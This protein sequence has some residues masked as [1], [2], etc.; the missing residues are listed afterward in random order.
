MSLRETLYAALLEHIQH[1]VDQL[2]EG[3][4]TINEWT[5]WSYDEIAGGESWVKTVV[6]YKVPTEIKRNGEQTWHFDGTLDDLIMEIDGSAQ[7]RE[8]NDDDR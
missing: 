4:N 6:F 7:A 3:I 5:N 1:E 8:R 2:A